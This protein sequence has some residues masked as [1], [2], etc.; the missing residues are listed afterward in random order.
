VLTKALSLHQQGHLAEAAGLYRK[1]LA[2]N[3][4]NADA[5]HLLGVI[6]FQSKNPSAA[7]AL[8]DRALRL[9][10]NN[11]IFHSNRGNALKDLKRFDEAVTSFDRALALKPDFAEALNNRGLALHELKRFDDALESY[12]RSLAIKPHHAKTFNNRGL[13]LRALKRFDDALASYDRALALEPNYADAFSNR[14]NVL[15]DLKR[16]ED[17]LVNYDLALA[18]KPDFAEA[19]NNR[20]TVLQ[21]LRRYGDAITSY[22]EALRTAP[23]YAE[24][25]ANLGN[26]LRELK[27]FDEAIASFDR[28][29]AIKPNFVDALGNRGNLMKERKNFDEAMADFDR[30]MAIEPDNGFSLGARLSCKLSICDWKGLDDEFR[31]LADSIAA[32]RKASEPFHVLAT[33]LSAAMQKICSEIYIREKHRPSSLLP[34]FSSPYRHTR[35]RLGYFS[36]DF[37]NHPVA[38]L[39]AG[40]FEAHDRT[41]F[42]VT[43]FALGSVKR[44]SMRMRLENAFDRFIELGAMSDKDVALLARQ[45]EIDIAIDLGGFTT[46]SRTD[47]FAMRAA[48][49]QVNYLGYPGTMGADYIDYLIADPI[50][51]PEDQQQYY[52]EKIAYLPHSYQPNDSKRPIAA[53]PVTRA[54]NNLPEDGFVFCCFNNSYKFAAQLFDIWMRLLRQ[55]PSSVMWL[56]SAPPSVIHNLRREAEARG[57]SGNRIVFAP[58]VQAPEDHLARLRL[59]DLFLD[60]LPYNAHATA[61]DALWAGLP[62]LTCLGETFPGRVAG[63]LLNSIGLAELITQNLDAYEVKA[64][65][66]AANPDK[67]LSLRERLAANRGIYP[68]FDTALFTSHIEAAYRAMWNRQQAG[69]APEHIYV[70]AVPASS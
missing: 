38:H 10:P 40:L 46:G 39:T 36:A 70:P 29:L 23:E 22:Q 57:V 69:L 56:S 35:I 43:A 50:L 45:L 37:C 3:P 33:P 14:G 61:S 49:I 24:A 41:A 8:I 62:V 6:E 15:K 60:T 27:R 16:F 66:L 31:K 30:A 63:S 44:D 42:E 9:V 17:A 26:A 48:P 5:L 53:T 64:L 28:A 52:T 19:L 21:E 47:V 13:A 59:A 7:L 18:I 12:R 54:Q 20:G 68:L 2:Q 32:G 58:F 51:I 25:H 11:P 34:K 65:E 4:K 55:L 67:L 1:V